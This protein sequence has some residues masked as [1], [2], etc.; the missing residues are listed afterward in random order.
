MSVPPVGALDLEIFHGNAA[1]GI[2][3]INLVKRQCRFVFS[4]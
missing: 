4:H 2:S 3:S 1:G